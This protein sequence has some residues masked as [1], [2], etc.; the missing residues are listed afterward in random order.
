M[1]NII[2][3]EEDLLDRISS[4]HSQVLELL[5]DLHFRRLPLYDHI[6][7]LAHDALLLVGAHIDDTALDLSVGQ[8]AFD[9]HRLWLGGHGRQAL[10]YD[11]A[12]RRRY[13][14]ARD[15]DHL[16]AHGGWRRRW[17]LADHEWWRCDRSRWLLTNDLRD[18]FNA[19]I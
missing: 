3:Y 10:D 11:F 9:D 15:G 8:P 18:H 16:A 7:G 19:N 5:F 17:S 12:R 13:A 4:D 6:L 14:L 1:I 2:S